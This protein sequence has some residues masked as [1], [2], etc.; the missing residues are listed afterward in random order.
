M[1][2]SSDLFDFERQKL[3]VTHSKTRKK[4]FQKFWQVHKST[5]TEKI[6]KMDDNKHKRRAK[7]NEKQLYIVQF[8]LLGPATGCDATTADGWINFVIN[9]LPC[10]KPDDVAALEFIADVESSNLFLVFR[11]L[12]EK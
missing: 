8:S 11:F 10:I 12:F 3:N 7:T 1:S 4:N 5:H 9:V 2:D 6:I